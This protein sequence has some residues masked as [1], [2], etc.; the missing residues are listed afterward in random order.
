MI[1]R[2]DTAQTSFATDELE[3]RGIATAVLPMS[4]ADALDYLERRMALGLGP[5]ARATARRLYLNLTDL[6]K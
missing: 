1:S 3:A 2:H 4:R 5:H 6:E